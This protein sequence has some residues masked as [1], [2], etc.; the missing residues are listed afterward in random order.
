MKFRKVFP[1]IIFFVLVGSFVLLNNLSSNSSFRQSKIIQSSLINNQAVV[2]KEAVKVLRVVDGDTIKVLISNKEDVVR[3]IGID[4]PEILDERKPIQCFGKEA[5]DKAKEILNGKII[6]LE[7]DST[8]ENRDEYGRLLRYV[9][10]DS[11]NFNKFMISQGYARE[12][13]FKGK[14]YKYQ[15]EFIQAEKK[16]R[17]EN[18]GLWGSCGNKN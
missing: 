1:H 2:V 5:S 9:F 16:A 15:T 17:R 8:Q 6:T 10:I 3:L 18:K 7:Q 13:T 11:S 12:Y 4:S 14:I